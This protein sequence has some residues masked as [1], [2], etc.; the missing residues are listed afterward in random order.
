MGKRGRKWFTYNEAV[1]RL[2]G[3]QE[4]VEALRRS[5]LKR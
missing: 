2:N 3:R 4:L 1:E 5:T